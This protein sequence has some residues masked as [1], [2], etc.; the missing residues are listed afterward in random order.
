MLHLRKGL[1]KSLL[2]ALVLS[3]TWA[4]P[5]VVNA[6]LT[7]LPDVAATNPN[8]TDPELAVTVSP[9]QPVPPLSHVPTDSIPLSVAVD[10]RSTAAE[11]LASNLSLIMLDQITDSLP[12]NLLTDPFFHYTGP[13]GAQRVPA[14]RG[15]AGV[16]DSVGANSA[17]S[18]STMM[19][20]EQLE[21][22]NER[23]AA[24]VIS[25][26]FYDVSIKPSDLSD[27]NTS[28]MYTISR[29]GRYY[30]SQD[31]LANST[32]AGISIIKI[33]A[34][35]VVFDLNQATITQYGSNTN[36][37][38]GVEIAA[39]QNNVTIQNGRICSLQ[40]TSGIGIKVNASCKNLVFKN[41]TIADIQGTTGAGIS[42]AATCSNLVFQDLI[43]SGCK[44]GIDLV[45]V[46]SVLIRNVQC[47]NSTS[48]YG[49]DVENATN[50]VILDSIFGKNGG[51]GLRIYNGTGTVVDNCIA[52]NN[53]GDGYLLTSCNTIWLKN[54]TASYNNG[55]PSVGFHVVTSSV[56]RFSNCAAYGQLDGSKALGWYFEDTV[57]TSIIENC[58]AYRQYNT[59]GIAAGIYFENNNTYCVVRNCL[60]Y[61]NIGSTNSYGF[62]DGSPTS[63][64]LLSHNVA[65]G[66]GASYPGAGD[67]SNG[68]HTNYRITYNQTI[69]H[70]SS[71]LIIEKI[72]TDIGTINATGILGEFQ[73]LSIIS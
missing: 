60:L 13:V 51:P 61:D 11:N 71:N 26:T 3:L 66:Q 40:G 73:N 47:V 59:G 63:T 33:A 7:A 4:N 54:C 39:S 19:Q 18:A 50:V 21:N 38:V 72:L 25:P 10:P 27:V 52:N 9:S 36:P 24:S 56:C 15:V 69:P 35:N 16:F 49:L 68:D 58:H 12:T 32:V 6:Q 53:T 28:A 5:L 14:Q 34:S 43:V 45:T 22:L 65:Y 48:S 64:T 70:A 20:L 42:T 31:I 37:T 17:V 2:N 57:S 55:E 23:A 1:F 8:C 41:L 30:L 62:Y 29:H 46:N 44:T 67:P